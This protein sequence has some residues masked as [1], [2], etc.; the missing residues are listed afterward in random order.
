[1]MR[2]Y[3]DKTPPKYRKLLVNLFYFLLV[4]WGMWMMWSVRNL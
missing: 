3:W 4:I 2:K 1:M